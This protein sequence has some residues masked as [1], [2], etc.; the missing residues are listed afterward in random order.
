MSFMNSP[1][2]TGIISAV[3]CNIGLFK[4]CYDKSF[5]HSL[6]THQV[7]A[8]L[9]DRV[10]QC[11]FERTKELKPGQSDKDCWVVDWKDT[12]SS[13]KKE[14]RVPSGG[15]SWDLI[16]MQA[17]GVIG[18]TLELLHIYP[19]VIPQLQNHHSRY[20]N[21]EESI[22]G[23]P[24]SHHGFPLLLSIKQ[25]LVVMLDFAEQRNSE[26]LITTLL[27]LASLFG[28]NHWSFEKHYANPEPTSGIIR[29]EYCQQ[30]AK[31][32]MPCLDEET[33]QY[34]KLRH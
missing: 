20:L 1:P 17:N 18:S 5:V 31:M 15:L 8:D 23:I 14:K 3:T 2:A 7:M 30:S 26:E 29:S 11:V 6:V 16:L 25:N 24:V 12:L 10:S 19:E 34:S 21:T 27:Q 33:V 13:S 4:Q 28:I 9:M 22:A 32:S